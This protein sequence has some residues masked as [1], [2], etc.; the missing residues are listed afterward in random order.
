MS[1]PHNYVELFTKRKF[2]HLLSLAKFLS[3]KLLSCVNNNIKLRI[4]Q[5][6][7]RWQKFHIYYIVYP[8]CSITFQVVLCDTDFFQLFIAAP[9]MVTFNPPSV[10]GRYEVELGRVFSLNCV[11]NQNI[12]PTPFQI[13]VSRPSDGML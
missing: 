8:V 7:P 12:Y 13:V 11:L 9:P 6:L 1:V 3:C 2:H 10:D 4:W 5:P